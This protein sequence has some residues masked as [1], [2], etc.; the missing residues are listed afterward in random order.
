MR[1]ID[2]NVKDYDNFQVVDIRYIRI[3]A[4]MKAYINKMND[5]YNVIGFEYDFANQSDSLGVVVRA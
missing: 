1:A 4:E 5:T 3:P 2:I